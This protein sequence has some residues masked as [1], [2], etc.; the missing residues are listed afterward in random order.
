MPNAAQLF[1]LVAV[2]FSAIIHEYCHGWMA[3]RSGDPTARLA[4]RLTLNPIPHIDPIGTVILPLIL[5]AIPG[6]P[7]LFAYAKP[8]PVNPYNLRNPRRDGG[9]VAFAGPAINLLVAL[10]LGAL[11]QLLPK[12]LLFSVYLD[13][14]V[15]ANVMLAVFNLIPVPPLDGSKVLFAIL[16]ESLH[17]VEVFLETYG[18]WLFLP[19]LFLFYPVLN[20]VLSFIY[21][22]LTG[23]LF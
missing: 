22:L 2:I 16:P 19:L 15:F 21:S 9:L 14:A 5:M 20:P 4:G 7:V 23:R 17:N 3:D 8:V 13:I 1:F 18:V 11:Y 10:V 6:N 12:N